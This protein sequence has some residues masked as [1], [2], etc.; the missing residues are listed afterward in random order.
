MRPA[1]LNTSHGSSN[2]VKILAKLVNARS[3]L[4]ISLRRIKILEI[5]YRVTSLLNS[6][7]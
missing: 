2:H 4:A 3:V 6:M 1:S 7:I 5:V